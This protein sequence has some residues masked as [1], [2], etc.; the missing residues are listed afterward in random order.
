MG[1]PKFVVSQI[2]VWVTWGFHL[3][4]ASCGNEMHEACANSGDWYRN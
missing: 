4:L 1:I 3:W 2:G